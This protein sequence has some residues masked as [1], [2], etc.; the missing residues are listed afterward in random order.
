MMNNTLN[1][2][3]WEALLKTAVIQYSYEENSSMPSE[4]ELKALELPENYERKLSNFIKHYSKRRNRKSLLYYGRKAASIILI[5]IGIT[6]IG[7]LQF[8]E[9]RA[10]CY[11]VFIEIREKYIQVDFFPDKSEDESSSRL[12][13]L[14][15]GFYLTQS[16]ADEYQSF[17]QYENSSNDIIELYIFKQERTIYL[18][19]E[20]YHVT[21]I[22]IN[23]HNGKYFESTDSNFMN[24]VIWNTDTEYFRLSSSMDKSFLL[25]LA[26]KIK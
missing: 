16:S 20:H 13:N 14:P 10:A 19:N 11:N 3:L 12:N 15:D 1:N 21:D 8:E 24:Y 7:L 6:F 5:I 4:D 9:I 18:D 25:N 26:E 17:W 2:E 22:Q 23:G